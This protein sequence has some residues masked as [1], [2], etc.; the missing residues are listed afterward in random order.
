MQLDQSN[1]IECKLEEA[2]ILD[3]PSLHVVVLYALYISI[4]QSQV[5]ASTCYQQDE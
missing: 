2:A 5:V 3:D 1:W 4:F